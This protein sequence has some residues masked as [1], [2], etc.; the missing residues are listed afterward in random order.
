MS[1][2]FPMET[3]AMLEARASFM[4]VEDQLHA[5]AKTADN[6]YV[7]VPENLQLKLQEASQMMWD[8]AMGFRV[9]KPEVEVVP[10][11]SIGQLKGVSF[12]L[13]R[14]SYGSLDEQGFD[15]DVVHQKIA[16]A[17]CNEIIWARNGYR[18]YQ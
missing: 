15:L 18:A 2:L 7:R 14:I 9:P 11:R 4:E 13:R 10:N 12:D 5:L 17:I 16:W 8:V 6:G 1:A 3:H